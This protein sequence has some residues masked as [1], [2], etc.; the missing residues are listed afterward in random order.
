M[1]IRKTW[2]VWALCALALPAWGK[3][4]SG[5]QIPVTLNKLVLK[6][7][8]WLQTADGQ[9]FY[10]NA[11]RRMPIYRKM[12]DGAL[13]KAEMPRELIAVPFIES[14]FQNDAVST[15]KAAG[16]WQ[17]MPETGRRLGLVVNDTTDERFDEKL[18]TGAALHYLHDLNEQFHDWRLALLGYNL[19]EVRVQGLIDE[20]TDDPWAIEAQA[21]SH[22]HY[23]SQF[24]A[25]VYQLQSDGLL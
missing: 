23:L 2:V 19:G 16:L 17:I 1:H 11:K 22:D 14:G 21:E 10:T 25:V 24:T 15:L 13:A 18:A 12:I 3:A 20:G 4:K 6:Q 9:K 7:L 8:D 5:D